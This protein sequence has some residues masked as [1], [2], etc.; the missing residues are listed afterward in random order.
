MIFSYRVDSFAASLQGLRIDKLFINSIHAY[1]S[2]KKKFLDYEIYFLLR[3][4]NST[5][6][7]KFCKTFQAEQIALSYD[8]DCSLMIHSSITSI[9]NIMQ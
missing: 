1:V 4:V 7:V 6:N 8:D 3:D 5:L 2:W 9:D